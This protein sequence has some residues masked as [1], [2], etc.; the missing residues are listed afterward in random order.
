MV[1]LHPYI[2]AYS[3]SNGHSS[4]V[5]CVH[6]MLRRG[7]WRELCDGSGPKR[8]TVVGAW[9]RREKHWCRRGDADGKA[10]SARTD[11]TFVHAF[12]EA[13]YELK[14][15]GLIELLLVRNVQSKMY[16]DGAQVLPS[17]QL[18]TLKQPFDYLSFGKAQKYLQKEFDFEI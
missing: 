9:I 10:S 17:V 11:K 13:M 14:L 7:L 3:E 4:D 15:C 2:I 5:R 1:Y 8:N 18:V 6:S 16:E 12:E